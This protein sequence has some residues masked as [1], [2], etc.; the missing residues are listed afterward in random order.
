MTTT[1]MIFLGILGLSSLLNNAQNVQSDA[2]ATSGG[3]NA[4]TAT[5]STNNTFY[6]YNSGAITIGGSN[7]AFIGYDTGKQNTTGSQ[8]TFVGA[9]AGVSNTTGFSNVFIGT[10]AGALS[11]DAQ[12][13]TFV[14][15]SSGSRLRGSNNVALG[16][17]AGFNTNEA[18][19]GN[20]FIG[21]NSGF[22]NR[23]AF[24]I[25][26]KL[27]IDNSKTLTPLIWGDFANDELKLN[28]KVGI[29]AVA[30]FPTTA[31]TVNVS[32][33]KLFV[34][35]GIL[36]DEI[37]VNLSNAGTWAD[38]VFAKNYKLPTLLEV[39]KQIQEKGHLANMPSAEE[40]AANGIEL[41]EMA[42][43]Q[44]EKIEELTLYLI[45]QNKEINELKAMVKT[46]IEK[47]K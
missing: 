7:N 43:L 37:R 19:T 1:K 46:L 26:N 39:E 31:G 34:T 38:Y 13:N 18:S 40:V 29:G 27:F 4:G 17:D 14:G 35:G 10:G 36:T 30:V 28:G 23:T 15:N 12:K 6:G 22:N 21:A 47:N 44:Q 5:G 2:F 41:G 32:N 11:Q 45:Q 8:N 42:K 3:L 24:E 16:W 9:V 33:Y 25:S 20:I